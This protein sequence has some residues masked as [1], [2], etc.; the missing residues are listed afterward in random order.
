MWQG[1][2]V[3]RSSGLF[4]HNPL[5]VKQVA[6]GELKGYYLSFSEV[7]CL[8][9]D[10]RSSSHDSTFHSVLSDLWSSNSDSRIT[11]GM[12]GRMPTLP[13]CVCGSRGL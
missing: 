12:H 13:R 9:N 4:S 11:V 3:N 10:K 1:L 2:G 7:S 5:L 6:L 8:S